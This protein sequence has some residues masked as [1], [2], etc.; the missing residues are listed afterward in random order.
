[1]PYFVPFC[2]N[3]VD[4]THPSHSRFL[5]NLIAQRLV[6]LP[7]VAALDEEA[8]HRTHKEIHAIIMSALADAATA[9]IKLSAGE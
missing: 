7:L 9:D 2:G 3:D 4:L 8:Y 1:M 6:T 5:G